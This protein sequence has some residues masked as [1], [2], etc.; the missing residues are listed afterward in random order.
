[1]DRRSFTKLSLLTTPPPQ[2]PIARRVAAAGAFCAGRA[3]AHLRISLWG[4]R[5]VLQMQ[6]NRACHGSRRRE[7]TEI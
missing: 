5:E 6:S 3:W 4:L 7:G 1:M 2:P